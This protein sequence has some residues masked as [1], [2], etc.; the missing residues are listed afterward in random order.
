M[1]SEYGAARER[2]EEARPIYR[3]IGDRL[4]EAN[5]IKALGDVHYSLDEYGAA[6]ERYEEARPIYRDIGARL[7]EINCYFGLADLDRHGERWEA[8]EEKYREALS[9]YEETGMAFN[10]ALALQRLGYTAEGAGEHL[11]ARD[12]YQAALELFER[13]GSPQAE[14]VRAD[15]ET[16]EGD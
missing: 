6:R 4:G 8:A 11:Q 15:L 12:Y 10:A 7:G 5:C 13:I 9:Y 16:L 2:Y 14:S 1:L 3:D